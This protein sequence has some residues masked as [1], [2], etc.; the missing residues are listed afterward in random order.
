M[1]PDIALLLG[2]FL[3]VLA[4]PSLLSALIEHRAPYVALLVGAGGVAS[5]VYA[6]QTN[7]GGYAPADVPM[8]LY[9][10]IGQ[11]MQSIL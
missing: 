7:E 8:V 9:S 6:Y 1:T 11:L 10:V 5:A 2:L 3:V 4:I